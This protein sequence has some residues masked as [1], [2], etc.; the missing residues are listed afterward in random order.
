MNYSNWLDWEIKR[1]PTGLRSVLNPLMPI[2]KQ[3][4]G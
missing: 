3:K 4:K 1:I 2:T